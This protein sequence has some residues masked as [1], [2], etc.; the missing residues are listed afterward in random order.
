MEAWW[1][2]LGS[3]L[4]RRWARRRL[5]WYAEEK[6]ASG[7]FAAFVGVSF[8]ELDSDESKW[9][10]VALGDACLVHKRNGCILESIP[11]GDPSAFGYHPKLVPSS[12][13]RQHGL[14]DQV[15]CASG[16]ARAGDRLL[17]LTDAIAAW[18][19]RQSAESPELV[20][21]F[22]QLLEANAFQELHELIAAERES[23]RLR[24][25]DVAAVLAYPTRPTSAA[26]G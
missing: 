24:N 14:A 26:M 2:A 18:Y 9:M 1:A 19:L 13:D 12:I 6:A 5:P 16:T 4:S 20:Q 7:A 8:S 17:L 11:I 21:S 23:K 3:R 15:I 25:D 10:T 22:E